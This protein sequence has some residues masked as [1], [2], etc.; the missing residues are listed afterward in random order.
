MDSAM[1]NQLIGCLRAIRDT[2]KEI[3]EKL[4]N[5]SKPGNSTKPVDKCAFKNEPCSHPNLCCDQCEIL[6]EVQ[7]KLGAVPPEN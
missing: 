2:L 6:D 5:S 1:W 3:N 7:R 4:D